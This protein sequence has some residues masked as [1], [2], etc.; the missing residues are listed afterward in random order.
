MRNKER[1]FIIVDLRYLCDIKK[2]VVYLVLHDKFSFKEPRLEK[3]KIR[4]NP[5]RYIELEYDKNEVVRAI[6]KNS[7]TGKYCVMII[8]CLLNGVLD[9]YQLLQEKEIDVKP[10]DPAI[11]RHMRYEFRYCTEDLTMH[12]NAL[13]VLEN[14]SINKLIPTNNGR[15]EDMDI[16][17]KKIDGFNFGYGNEYA[18]LE[19]CIRGET[20]VVND[21]TEILEI[22]NVNVEF[23]FG[24]LCF[25][26]KNKMVLVSKNIGGS[27]EKIVFRI[28]QEQTPG[29]SIFLDIILRAEAENKLVECISK[30]FIF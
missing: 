26:V 22:P 20:L 8:P 12:D 14:G 4:V 2:D 30:Y 5:R 29:L 18:V 28:K 3:K 27:D 13:I 24:N 6:I 25:E 7:N 19:K 15:I 23:D 1:Q 21:F 10:L 9:L 17:L 16:Y 11:W